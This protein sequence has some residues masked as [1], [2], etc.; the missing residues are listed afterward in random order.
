MKIDKYQ[1][2][3]VLRQPCQPTYLEKVSRIILY[4]D[5][6]SAGLSVKHCTPTI[7]TALWS[8]IVLAGNTG[9]DI[10]QVVAYPFEVTNLF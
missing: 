3:S 5:P 1:M 7:R 2:L 9:K 4:G 8:P 6:G 10:D